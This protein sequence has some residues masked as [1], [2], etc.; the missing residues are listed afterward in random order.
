[1]NGTYVL[2][3]LVPVLILAVVLESLRRG[4]LRERHAL[5]WI[6]AGVLALVAGIFPSSVGW[7]AEKLGIEVPSNL[8]FFSGIVILFLV[9]LQHASELT[10]TEAQVRTLAERVA[11]LELRMDQ[12]DDR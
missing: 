10:R 5:W 3:V 9:S 2:G 4:R 7:V 11:L 8:V 6:I 1:M 12:R